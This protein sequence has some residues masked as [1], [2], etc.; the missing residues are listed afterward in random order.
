M[1]NPRFEDDFFDTM[2]SP[3]IDK[4]CC[5]SCML[6]A[7]DVKFGDSVTPGAILFKCE[8]F[9]IKPPEIMDDYEECPYFIDENEE[10]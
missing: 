3:D 5:K 7:K 9:S 8:V 4:I 6:R 1:K 2:A 10:E